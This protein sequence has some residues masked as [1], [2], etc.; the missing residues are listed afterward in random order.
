MATNQIII[1]RESQLD[2]RLRRHSLHYQAT[3]STQETAQYCL[4]LC[5]K[6]RTDILNEGRLRIVSSGNVAN[7]T[8]LIIA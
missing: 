2:P 7:H 6:A 5:L 4:K 3:D 8:R 1:F